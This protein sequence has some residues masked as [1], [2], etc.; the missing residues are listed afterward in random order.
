MK[1]SV[2]LSECKTL[3]NLFFISLLW[4]RFEM[5][6]ET[7]VCCYSNTNCVDIEFQSVE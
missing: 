5:I 1:D 2:E 6:F 3:T 4:I 7:T